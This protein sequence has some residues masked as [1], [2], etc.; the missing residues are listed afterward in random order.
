[1]SRV[2][3][4]DH[5]KTA[6]D[7]LGDAACLPDNLEVHLDMNHSGAMLALQH[8]QPEVRFHYQQIRT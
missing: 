2:V 6:A 8:F 5:H 4:V 7:A 3:I 1:M